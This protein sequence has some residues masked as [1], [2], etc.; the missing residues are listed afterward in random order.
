M[1]RLFTVLSLLALL[2]TACEEIQNVV[3]KEE[4]KFADGV[5][6]TQQF[7]AAEGEATIAFTSPLD[8]RVVEQ[9][10]W[11]SVEP[12]SGVAGDGSFVIN[13]ALNNTGEERGASV[14]IILSDNEEHSV[15]VKQEANDHF[16]IDGEGNYRVAAAGGDVDVELTTN[17][18]YTVHISED[19]AEWLTLAETRALRNETL[20]FA[21]A[22]NEEL[23]ERRAEVVVKCGEE[24][25]QSIIFIQ[26]AAPELFEADSEGNYSVEAKGG[27]IE[28]DV[29]TNIEYRVE[30]D[31]AAQW[32]QLAETRA[33]REERLSFTI[34][35]NKS[36]EERST[37][38]RIVDAEGEEL[39]SFE[40]RQAAAEPYF[41]LVAEES[42]VVEAAGDEIMVKVESNIEYELI[43]DASATWLTLHEDSDAASGIYSFVVADNPTTE[44]RRTTV[45]FKDTKGEELDKFEV[46]QEAK[47]LFE[48]DGEGN[49]TIAAKG[50]IIELVVET[51]ID[52]EV[53]IPEEASWITLAETRA[54]HTDKLVFNVSENS[55][56]EER[57]TTVKLVGEDD[58]V[59]QSF[60]VTQEAALPTIKIKG[61]AK[62]FSMAYDEEKLEVEIEANVEY[63]VKI[64]ETAQ[65]LRL[66]ETHAMNKS[67]LS[68]ELDSN[69]ELEERSTVVELLDGEESLLA[70][71]TVKQASSGKIFEKDILPLYLIKS[72]ADSIVLDISTNIDYTVEF[73]TD[74]PWLTLAETRALRNE[75]LTFNL[76]A[77]D[78]NLARYAM[79]ALYDGDK[80]LAKFDVVQ[81]AS[82][83]GDNV[84]SYTTRGNVEIDAKWSTRPIYELMNKGVSYTIFKSAV[85][86]IE[87]STFK[88]IT[89]LLSVNIP[90]SV[91]TVEPLAF[92]GCVNLKKFTGKFATADGRDL[93]ADG[94]LVA[95][96]LSGVTNYT[97]PESATKVGRGVFASASTLQSITLHESVTEVEAAAVDACVS[98]K[99]IYCKAQTPPVATLYNGAWDAF[100]TNRTTVKVYVPYAVVDSYLAAEGWKEYNIVAY[101]F[102]KGEVYVPASDPTNPLLPADS[103]PANVKFNHRV[104]LV[105]HT[106]VNCGNC[107]RVM[108]G[109][110]S[111]AETKWHKHYNAV[112]VHGG[113]YAPTNKDNGY[114]AAAAV[115]DNY[116]WPNG[117]PAVFFNFC[118]GEGNI[119]DV[120]TFVAQ[121][122]S[123]IQRLVKSAGADAGIAVA[124][125]A[126]DGKV[127]VK[128]GVKAAVAQEYR[129]TAWL[130]ENDVYN[131]E[132]AG[133]KDGVEYHI[134]QDHTLRNI[135]GSYSDEDLSGDS[136]GVVS[137]GSV[138]EHSFEIAVTDSRWVVENMDVL[139]IVSADCGGYFEVVNT[140]LCP[141][142]STTAF[143]YV[144]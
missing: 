23:E 91:T 109:L 56:I 124:T 143:E 103:N 48:A 110:Q 59:L 141:I 15:E 140:A 5:L 17:L 82:N 84:V 34:A 116:Y 100:G 52:Y 98:M 7:S 95:T 86:T 20:T 122:A 40:V 104:L 30:I 92:A 79:V 99:S 115:V 29:K 118:D 28:V 134:Y 4:F 27:I 9:A 85:T 83:V 51:N 58:S 87:S 123:K 133:R 44:E 137:A 45:V 93:V 108:D 69:F 106:G 94:R 12:E 36:I 114:S 129:V 11:I 67:K 61:D 97:L 3:P 42:Y 101:D 26:E 16:S 144:E 22:E 1:K 53:V 117:Y 128:I 112:A 75:K 130:L 64:D 47:G 21:V 66:A 19:A 13:V 76:A 2:F 70:S 50:G 32:L 10:E 131:P 80:L 125:G 54:V 63:S 31:E 74:S 68:F 24:R 6:T 41:E 89:E 81:W 96:A 111:F 113:G 88:G 107:P 62:E 38:V 43:I 138:K 18:D 142:N 119:G 90:E 73:I 135:A 127:Y 65:W 136:I 39:Q 120:G 72:A 8:W 35:E 139:V 60:G 33:V 37:T 102:E 57:K 71:F 55:D 46:V 105:D 132:Q 77:N 126:A 78:T 49:Y 14:R 25:L 121:N